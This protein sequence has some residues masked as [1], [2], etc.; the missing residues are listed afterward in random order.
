[1]LAFAFRMTPSDDIVD[2]IVAEYGGGA[3]DHMLGLIWNAVRAGDD[4]MVG[5]LDHIMRLIEQRADAFGRPR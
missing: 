5:Q 2:T 1:M 3:I 4:A